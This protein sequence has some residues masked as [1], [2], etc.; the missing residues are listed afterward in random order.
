[1]D[2]RSAIKSRIKDFSFNYLK[3]HLQDPDQP[4]K[5]Y[6]LMLKTHFETGLHY[7]CITKT[8]N[9]TKYP[10]S[11]KRWKRLLSKI[12]SQVFTTLLYTT[13]CKDDLA[14]AASYYSLLFNIPHNPDFCNIVPEC[15]Y[16]NNQGN[17]AEWVRT[18]DKQTK[19]QINK[20]RSKSISDTVRAKHSAGIPTPFE[21][22]S[23]RLYDE[24][25]LTNHMQKPEIA[26]KC[27]ESARKTLLERYG[28]EHN[29]QIPEVAKRMAE[30]RHKTLL[31]RYGVGH[32]MR[33]P[34]FSRPAREK[35]KATVL[36]KYGVA[37]PSQIPGRKER[38]GPTISQALRSKPLVTC[39]FCQTETRR[40]GSHHNTCKSNPNRRSPPKAT[41]VHCGLTAN[42]GNIAR[43]H[44]DKCKN[45]ETDNEE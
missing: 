34:V 21:V 25:G 41:C 5:Q 42:P 4:V 22:V 7:L 30:A 36:Q 17:L 28:V 27:R 12:P 16:E 24:T 32:I 35:A 9:Y 1:M 39:D 26:A 40:L 38:V 14:V 6:K 3:P 20:K 37:N 29:T 13:D 10:G 44:N 45:K 11:G 2:Y 23:Q 43:F 33:S 19:D 31:E 15:G 8:K 18:A